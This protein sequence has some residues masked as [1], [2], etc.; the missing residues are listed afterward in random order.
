MSYREHPSQ[1]M[2]VLGVGAQNLKWV[3]SRVF[4]EKWA[5]GSWRQQCFRAHR[6]EGS[7]K[8]VLKVDGCENF[9]ALAKSSL[10]AKD[11][12]NGTPVVRNGPPE[13]FSQGTY[14][15]EY[16]PNVLRLRDRTKVQ[17]KALGLCGQRLP[18]LNLIPI[19]VIDPGKATVGFIHSFGVNL[20][21]LLF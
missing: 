6:I 21:S 14:G 15:R 16:S 9:G 12:R 4:C 18:E 19:Q 7:R 13:V 17:W 20:Y 8:S 5:G 11:A 1:R 3:P 2:K 10:L